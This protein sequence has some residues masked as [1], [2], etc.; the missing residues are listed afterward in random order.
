MDGKR[1][2]R[3]PNW[4]TAGSSVRPRPGAI[5]C[6]DPQIVERA[7][8]RNPTALRLC[9]QATKQAEPG[10]AEGWTKI[11]LLE[12]WPERQ[13]QRRPKRPATVEAHKVIADVKAAAREL[14]PQALGTLQEI[15][16]DKK[17]P[18]AARVTAATEILGAGVGA[19]RPNAWRR[20]PEMGP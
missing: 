16:E 5:R 3:T 10:N 6:P 15:M 17:A 19:G 12:A 13:L 18:P 9:E 2:P 7:L 14:T 1:K 11:N 4:T 20:K 8:D